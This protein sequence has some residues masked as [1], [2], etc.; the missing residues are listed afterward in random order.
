MNCQKNI[1]DDE[2][3]KEM[4]KL[5]DN[6]KKNLIESGDIATETLSNLH[7]QGE[8][9]KKIDDGIDVTDVNVKKSETIL[10]NISF[11]KNMFGFFTKSKKKRRDK[12]SKVLS[13]S[14]QNR[15]NLIKTQ[16]SL[17]VEDRFE[18]RDI[19]KITNET[20]K[21][22]ED[23]DEITHLSRRLTIMSEEMNTELEVQNEFLGKVTD[24]MDDT[25][26]KVKKLNKTIRR[27]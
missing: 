17:V 20:K 7:G 6:L 5:Y 1:D 4:Q 21:M 12:K 22:R 25:N 3:D 10:K 15:D 26:Y 8:D 14:T 2:Y 16:K 9:I 24:K 18:V 19:R 13:V 27:I 11:M 23:I